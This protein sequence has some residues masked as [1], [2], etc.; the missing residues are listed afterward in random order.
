MARL[1]TANANPK[2]LKLPNISFNAAKFFA[3]HDPSGVS[4]ALE[5]RI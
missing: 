5:K 4:H 2:A 1:V 3:I